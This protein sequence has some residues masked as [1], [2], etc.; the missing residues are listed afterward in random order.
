MPVEFGGYAAVRQ[1]ENRMAF[2][3]V[4]ADCQPKIFC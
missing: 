4:D 2:E 3:P 1:K